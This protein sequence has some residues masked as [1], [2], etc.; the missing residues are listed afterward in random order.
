MVPMTPTY[1]R[2]WLLVRI[3]ALVL[4]APLTS[5]SRNRLPS[6]VR[7]IGFINGSEAE[8]NEAFFDELEQLGYVHRGNLVV[9]TRLLTGA[10]GELQKFIGELAA[11]EIEFV[12]VGALPMAAAMRQANPAMPM[13]IATC[14]GMITNGFAETLEQPDGIVTGMD[15][16]PPGV[17]AKRLQLLKLAA[18]DSSR[19]A[20]LSTTP[21]TGGHETQ[22]AE[23]QQTAASLGVAVR[24]YR[25]GTPADLDAA[26]QAIAADGNDGLLNF[27]GGLSLFK[28]EQI[29]EF[30]AAHRLPAIYQAT[31]FAQDGGLMSWAPDI[32][33]QFRTAARYADQILQGAKPGD[34][35]IQHPDRYFLTVN[36][37][38]AE[39]I[40]MTL[41][42]ALL[43][44]TDKVV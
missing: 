3:G 26:L 35:P 17:T 5:C 43:A 23:A 22:L 11:M 31:L 7:R 20:L 34:L 21:G 13:V 44:L 19:I 6:R 28:R 29:V 27:Q 10:P 18:P 33:Q 12:V 37:R 41:P 9:E 40:G 2:R 8:M 4:F 32:N 38:A 15:E 25:A 14:P 39:R 30:A 16:L 1:N 24:P 42:V 36:S